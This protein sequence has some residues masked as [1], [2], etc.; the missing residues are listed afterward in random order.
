M[1]GLCRATP[2]KPASNYIELHVYSLSREFVVTDEQFI[3]VPLSNFALR[4]QFFTCGVPKTTFAKPR[5][6][7]FLF[8]VAQ[9]LSRI[10]L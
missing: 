10:Y 7:F 1:E 5:S 9:Y 4:L 3:A 2:A 8:V 6:A